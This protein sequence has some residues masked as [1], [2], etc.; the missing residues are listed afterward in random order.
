MYSRATIRAATVYI[1]RFN[2]L[3]QAII[4]KRS[5]TFMLFLP[6]K[7]TTTMQ[8]KKTAHCCDRNLILV[9]TNEAVLYLG[10]LAKYL[11]SFL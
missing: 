1:K 8:F 11:A 5:I 9:V 3:Q 2:E 4:F 6:R 7:K 10:L